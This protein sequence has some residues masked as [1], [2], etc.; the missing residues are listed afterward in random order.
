M[1][2]ECYRQLIHSVSKRI[3]FW[4]QPDK[5]T[6]SLSHI[7]DVEQSLTKMFYDGKPIILQRTTQSG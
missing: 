4:F 5:F 7:L 1:L 2:F 6:K 3:L